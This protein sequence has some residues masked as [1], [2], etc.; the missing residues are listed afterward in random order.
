MKPRTRLYAISLVC[1]LAAACLP[2]VA[3]DRQIAITIDDLPAGAANWMSAA[4]INQMTAKLL[5]PLREQKIPAV[6]FVNEKKLYKTGDVDERIKALSMWLDSGFEL[7]N[8]T[9]SHASLNRVGLKAWE[10]DVIQGE[11]VTRM[12]LTQH[13]LK[14]RYFSASVSRY[15][16]RSANPARSGSISGGS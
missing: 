7:G 15:R 1:I 3:A 8:H 9:F 16:T 4:E 14:L 2:C 12:L 11:T 6:G 13:N 5:T 10:E